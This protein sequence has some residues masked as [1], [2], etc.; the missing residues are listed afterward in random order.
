MPCGKSKRVYFERSDAKAAKRRINK[1]AS[2]SPVT[3]IY[4]CDD[5]SGYH[6]TTMDKKESRDITRRINKQKRA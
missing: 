2:L 5:C 6:L 3:N 1:D 4:W